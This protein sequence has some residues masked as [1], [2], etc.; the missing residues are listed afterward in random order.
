MTTSGVSPSAPAARGEPEGGVADADDAVPEDALHR[1]GDE[2]R[3]VGEVDDPG[4]GCEQ[5]HPLRDRERHGH[6]PQPVADPAR[7]RGLLAEQAEVEGEPLVDDPALE[8]ADPDRREDE[9]G[10]VQCLVEGRRRVTFAGGGPCR[11]YAAGLA[12]RARARRGSR[13]LGS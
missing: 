8:A 10:A 1:L 5:A 4:I 2:A 7:A 3:R 9:V 12:P 11:P 6:G 13:P